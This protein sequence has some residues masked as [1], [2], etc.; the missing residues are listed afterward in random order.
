MKML[1]FTIRYFKYFINR[2]IKI[3]AF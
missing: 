3:M 2:I 1:Y